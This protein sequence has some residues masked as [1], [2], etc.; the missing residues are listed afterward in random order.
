MV[1]CNAV[2]WCLVLVPA[3][4]LARRQVPAVAQRHVRVPSTIGTSV[5]LWRSD[6]L[7]ASTAALWPQTGSAVALTCASCSSP[8]P[9]RITC[10]ANLRGRTVRHSEYD[11]TT[12]NATFA[13]PEEH[14]SNSD[15]TIPTRSVSELGV[16]RVRYQ[17]VHRVGVPFHGTD[18]HN[19]RLPVW[20]ECQCQCCQLK[21]L[22]RQT[23]NNTTRHKHDKETRK[24]AYED[25]RGDA[26]GLCRG[27]RV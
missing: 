5:P 13:A 26:V 1:V 17:W 6:N 23:H 19:T 3:G 15:P 25:A 4:V 24:K 27:D 18:G 12:H 21:E 11:S 10:S 14:K 9:K 8:S 2:L 16:P 7:A 20:S 22:Q